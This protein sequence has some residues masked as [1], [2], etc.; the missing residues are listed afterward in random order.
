MPDTA[1]VQAAKKDDPSTTGKAHDRQQKA[2]DVCRD[3][4]A[5]TLNMRDRGG[6]YLP[7]FPKEIDT[8][9]SSRLKQSVLFNAFK[10]TVNGLVGMIF[11]NDPQP[12]EE[13][14]DII[15]GLMDDID[16]QGRH[17]TVF[18]RDVF[19][20]AMID[21]HA[22][23][24]VDYP[25]V[26]EGEVPTL[27]DERS[28]GL[29]PYWLDVRKQQVL[30][31]RTRQEQG[32]TVL[33]QAAI[34]FITT[35]EDGRFGEKEVERIRVYRIMDARGEDGADARYVS[36]EE[37]VKREKSKKIGEQYVME[38]EGRL[39]IPE[40]PLVAIYVNRTAYFESDPALLD[41]ALENIK[42]YQVRSDQDNA[43]HVCSIPIPIFT[44]L[45]EENELKV[46]SNVGVILPEGGSAVYLEPKG[47]ALSHGRLQIQDIE[48]RMAALGLAMLQRQTRSA[49]TAQAKMIDKA[50]SDSALAS[51]ARGLEDGLNECLR[52]TAMW[53]KIDG[54]GEVNVNFD[55]MAQQM[56]PQMID[57]LAKM[58]AQGYLTLQTLWELLIAGEVLPATF[59][60]V[61]ELQR[62]EEASEAEMTVMQKL[63][64]GK[65]KG[66]EGGPPEEGETGKE[67]EAGNLE[68]Q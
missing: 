30:S 54:G 9:Y 35:E 24:L 1:T 38:K 58:V 26:E 5:G 33:T 41:L 52:L 17:F 14:P 37:W 55:F 40:I 36:W 8:A 6:L 57:V 51:A 20:D 56:D 31:F 67:G 23:V 18:S 45:E 29:R 49:E 3:V 2:V 22:C 27:A 19:T 39:T 48:Q 34:Q 21:G 43:L 44:G 61:E 53:M 12:T 13:V 11:R 65:K 4:F 47:N 66:G 62:L 16:L 59:D 60:P 10:R 15:E 68:G 46:G 50:E 7:Q 28:K 63:F 32:R 25:S 42:H 64:G